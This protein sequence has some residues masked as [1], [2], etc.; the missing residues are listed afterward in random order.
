MCVRWSVHGAGAGA[1]SGK[2]LER[3]K[4]EEPFLCSP[5]SDNKPRFVYSPAL[6]GRI[7]FINYSVVGTGGTSESDVMAV[8]REKKVFAFTDWACFLTLR[9]S[10]HQSSSADSVQFVSQTSHLALNDRISRLLPSVWPSPSDGCRTTAA[11]A[12][13]YVCIL[14]GSD[15]SRRL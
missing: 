12:F 5:C 15:S 1:A 3:N 7:R 11:P 14:G 8:P 13:R 4:V 6:W 9:A 10:L 2:R